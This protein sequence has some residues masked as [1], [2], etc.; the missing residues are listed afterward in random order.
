MK[1]YYSCIDIGF[2][3]YVPQALQHQAINSKADKLGGKVTFYTSEDFLTLQTHDAIKS[4]IKESSNKVNGIIF[5]TLRQFFNHGQFNMKFLKEIILAGMEVHFARENF[6]VTSLADVEKV[7]PILYA[8]Q[9]VTQRDESKDYWK[10]VY[11]LM[12]NL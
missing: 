7:F 10:P 8:T 12:G 2:V 1:V 9:Y 3:R 11:E 4:K 6:S 5:F